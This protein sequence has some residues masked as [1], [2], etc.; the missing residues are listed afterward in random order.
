[1]RMIG[2]LPSASSDGSILTPSIAPE[3]VRPPMPLMP[4]TLA[5]RTSTKSSGWL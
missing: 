1:M 4:V 3:N 2:N 5:E